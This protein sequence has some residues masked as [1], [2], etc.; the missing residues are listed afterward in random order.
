MKKSS[1][2]F[3]S[4][5]ACFCM[6]PN[7]V[8]GKTLNDMNAELEKL[9]EQ[10]RVANSNKKLNQDE[11][12][13]LNN[14]MNNYLLKSIN[15][16]NSNKSKNKEITLLNEFIKYNF[17]NDIIDYYC[18]ISEKIVKIIENKSNK[19]EIYKY[20]YENIVIVILNHITNKNYKFAYRKFLRSLN[21][22]RKII[23]NTQQ[24]KYLI[25]K[26]KKI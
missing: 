4:M 3:L 18:I 13:K 1:M 5:L 19:S 21:K 24:D 9:K 22:I 2:L 8:H 6:M 11:L 26:I 25:K 16:N 12:N 23:K 17:S 7:V 10:Q 14:E 15:E 20:I